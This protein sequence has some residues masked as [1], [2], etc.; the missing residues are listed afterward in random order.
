MIVAEKLEAG[1]SLDMQNSRMKYFYDLWEL[2]RQFEF[3]GNTLANAIHNTFD[4]R[5]TAL[6]TANPVALPEKFAADASKQ[7]QWSSSLSKAGLEASTL[8][9]VRTAIETFL[10]EPALAA[11]QWRAFHAKWMPVQ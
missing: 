10:S 11:A 2:A 4:H 8:P 6:P 7:K 5:Q 1:A 9:E 3:D